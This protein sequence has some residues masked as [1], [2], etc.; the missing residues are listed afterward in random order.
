MILLGQKI[1][2][3]KA[4]V[5][6]V[7]HGCLIND[8]NILFFD[9]NLTITLQ[10]IE[11]KSDTLIIYSITLYEF[12]ITTNEPWF[13][14]LKYVFVS[15]HAM[16]ERWCCGGFINFMLFLAN[17]SLCS[18]IVSITFLHKIQIKRMRSVKGKW[19]KVLAQRQ[20]LLLY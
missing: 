11:V 16:A 1:V 13:G 8:A 5:L 15:V 6:L 19:L 18:L 2:Y 12:T 10:K 9:F 14:K 4:L 3:W 7:G 17:G 20:I